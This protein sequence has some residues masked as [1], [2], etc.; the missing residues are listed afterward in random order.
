MSKIIEGVK[1]AVAVDPLCPRCRDVGCIE[2]KIR[3]TRRALGIDEQ[4]GN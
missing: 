2:W 3:N 4:T 1:E